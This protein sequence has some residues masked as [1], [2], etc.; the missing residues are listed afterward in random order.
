MEGPFKLEFGRAQTGPLPPPEPASPAAW[1][2][3][4]S[5]EPS[6]RP[7]GRPGPRDPLSVFADLRDSLHSDDVGNPLLTRYYILAAY[8]RERA[9]Q[10]CVLMRIQDIEGIVGS[11]LPRAAHMVDLFWSN[12]ASHAA[13]WLSAGFRARRRGLPRG[14]V[15]FLND[16]VPA[17][18]A[19]EDD[20]LRSGAEIAWL[21]GATWVPR[22][23]PE[24]LP[25]QPA[26]AAPC[27]ERGTGSSEAARERDRHGV[28][29]E[30]RERPGKGSGRGLALRLTQEFCDGR[31]DLR[32]RRAREAGPLGMDGL[33]EW[34]GKRRRGAAEAPSALSSRSLPVAGWDALPE[35]VVASLL[36]DAGAT[37]VEIRLF[38][39]FGA[40]MNRGQDPDRLW[41]AALELFRLLPWAFDPYQAAEADTRL[42]GAGLAR[43]RLSLAPSEDAVAWQ[44]IAVSLAN[45]AIAPAAHEAVFAGTGDALAL[46]AELDQFDPQTGARRFPALCAPRNGTR[47]IRMLAIPGAAD[48]SGLELLPLAVD[49]AVRRATECLGVTSTRGLPLAEARAFIQETW[50]EDVASHG[51]V[52]PPGLEGT[53]AALEPAL[54][55]LGR[56]GCAA[57]ER[58]GTRMPIC[59][60]CSECRL[61]GI[62][63]DV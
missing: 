56:W 55:F 46:L 16:S 34:A 50:L 8:L 29:S 20:A 49:A 14:I 58:S 63:R 31:M 22:L 44:A 48:I 37:E 47:W 30:R 33:G 39:T 9:D 51:A 38:L 3:S 41:L 40:A 24:L 11:P 15:A 45:P 54:S 28:A 60:V 2:A 7:S 36:R 61:G 59:E 18:D 4:R 12:R 42:L 35:V 27:F 26:E 1:L 52:A 43:T 32:R 10:P 23:L 21:A 13:A 17:E 5:P 25:V 6:P 53:A 19:P 57:C 62:P